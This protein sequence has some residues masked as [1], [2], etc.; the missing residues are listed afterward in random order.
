MFKTLI[1]CPPSPSPTSVSWTITR[2][3]ENGSNTTETL[4]NTND[5]IMK[6]GFDLLIKNINGSFEGL[7]SCS[8]NDGADVTAGCVAV[9][10]KSAVL[11]TIQQLQAKL[12]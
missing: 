1:S 4:L 2:F 11:Y 6:A 12:W 10:G 7:Y 3:H 8:I 9:R 5:V